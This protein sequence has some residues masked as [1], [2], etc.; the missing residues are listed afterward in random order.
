[1]LFSSMLP[2]SSTGLE[3]L[4]LFS[5]GS[6]RSVAGRLSSPIY[7]PSSSL[8]SPPSPEVE[9]DIGLQNPRSPNLPTTGVTY[10]D[11]LA[12]SK[13]I[14]WPASSRL[15]AGPRASVGKSSSDMGASVSNRRLAAKSNLS[16]RNYASILQ[17]LPPPM[18]YTTGPEIRPINL[19][20]QG[21]GVGLGLSLT[22][23]LPLIEVPRST[24]VFTV[25]P[26]TEV[27][28]GS[29]SR[30]SSN[31][32]ESSPP[33]S[34]ASSAEE[35]SSSPS[36]VPASLSPSPIVEPP[37]ASTS[38]STTVPAGTPARHTQYEGL[39][40]G[41]PSHMQRAR[42]P[43]IPEEAAATAAKQPAAAPAATKVNAQHAGLG[44]GLPF[45]LRQAPQ[46]QASPNPAAS[47]S[48]SPATSR[49]AVKKWRLHSTV[50]EL[51]ST[52]KFPK[53]A[54]FSIPEVRSR[55]TSAERVGGAKKS[56]GVTAGEETGKAR[57]TSTERERRP[58]QR[59]QM[60]PAM[61][62]A[63]QSILEEDKKFRRKEGLDK[64][65][66]LKKQQKRGGVRAP[67]PTT[68]TM[69]LASQVEEHKKQ[70][71]NISQQQAGAEGSSKKKYTFLF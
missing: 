14:D 30:S 53:R 66:M 71:R 49:T 18:T 4:L 45:A 20:S 62:L 50:H 69:R 64:P 44:L 25:I 39:G 29:F 40:H 33:Q 68:P 32:P 7:A 41:L 51:F 21:S 60:S 19:F 58:S 3:S 34:I 55:K 10:S 17:V 11:L 13:Y 15:G 59:L 46:K 6:P 48:S 47:S 9:S 23:P 43:S 1:M 35:S 65:N 38:N 70:Q 63:A 16:E 57:S 27:T 8:Q 67:T 42:L 12:S 36:P 37:T 54:L 28:P 24:D 5:P 61:L 22:T 56:E 52:R 31:T 26:I 2:S